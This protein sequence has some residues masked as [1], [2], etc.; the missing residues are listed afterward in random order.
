MAP[1]PT[2]PVGGNKVGPHP[3]AHGKRGATCHG[4]TEGGGGPIG[5]AGT[6]AHRQALTMGREP[7][8]SLPVTRPTPPQG[9]SWDI[10]DDADD[11]RDWRATCGCAAHLRA[12]G[13]E[14]QVLK[15]NAGVRARQWSVERTHR[16]MHRFRRVLLRWRTTVRHDLGGLHVAGA[17]L[18][19]R[20]AGLVG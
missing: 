5:R 20:Q 7:I 18:P 15:R 17:Y 2:P 4:L 19:S 1:G 14:A 16:W 11:G 10:G 8:A 13:E 9:Q 12:R 6:G 3:T